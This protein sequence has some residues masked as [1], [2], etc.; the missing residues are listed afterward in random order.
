MRL[1][2]FFIDRPVFAVVIAVVKR[3]GIAQ[4]RNVTLVPVCG[5]LIFLLGFHG[6]ELDLNYSARPLAREIAAAAPNEKIV[7]VQG[8]KRDMVYG[9]AFYRNQDPVHYDTDGV[10]NGEH[11]LVTRSNDQALLDHYLA[12]RIYEPL[13]LYDTQGLAVYKVYGKNEWETIPLPP[14][15]K[16]EDLVKINPM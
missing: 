8:V 15:T 12:G 13:F 1:S 16:V 2:H 5:L 14:G 3:F 11:I 9:L 7:A 6:P 4:I 10:P